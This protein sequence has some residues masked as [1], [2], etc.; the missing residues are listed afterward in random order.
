MKISLSLVLRAQCL[1]VGSRPSPA[2]FRSTRKMYNTSHQVI[3]YGQ[4]NSEGPRQ[5]VDVWLWQLASGAPDRGRDF[6][7]PLGTRLL[8]GL[9]CPEPG[10]APR[11]SLPMQTQGHLDR[12]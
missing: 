9:G 5:D 6:L 11:A 2:W 12:C 10:V 3:I 4:G 1:G 8:L 7:S